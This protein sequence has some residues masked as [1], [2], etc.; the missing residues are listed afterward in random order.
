MEHFSSELL[1]SGNFPF[2]SCFN[3]YG[4]DGG[5]VFRRIRQN[6]AC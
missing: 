2:F 5:M 1:L 3:M 4:D 6:A